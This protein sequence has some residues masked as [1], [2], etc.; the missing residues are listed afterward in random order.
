MILD[1][2]AVRRD[3]IPPTIDFSEFQPAPCIAST[4]PIGLLLF[5]VCHACKCASS[6]CGS[7]PPSPKNPTGLYSSFAEILSNDGDDTEM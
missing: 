4:P 5:A 7:N 2:P 6:I 3:V 1:I